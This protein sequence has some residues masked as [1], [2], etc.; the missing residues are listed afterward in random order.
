MKKSFLTALLVCMAVLGAKAQ[1]INGRVVDETDAP[2][3]YATVVAMQLPDSTFLGGVTTD[4]EGR[5]TLEMAC[6]LLKISFVGYEPKFVNQPKGNLGTLK[7]NVAASQLQEVTIAAKRPE[8]TILP[9]KTVVG[10]ESTCSRRVPTA[11]TCCEKRPVC[12]WTVKTTS[13]SS[14]KGRPSFT[15][16]TGACIRWTRSIT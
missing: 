16:T 7:M 10:V 3:P 14:G 1:N 2:I 15:S 11:S 9:D 6:D 12:W 13:P 4:N 5:F 8:I